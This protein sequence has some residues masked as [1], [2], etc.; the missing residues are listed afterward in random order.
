VFDMLDV[1]RLE[2]AGA[3][4]QRLGVRVKARLVGER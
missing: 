2:Q 1:S 4:A 3:A